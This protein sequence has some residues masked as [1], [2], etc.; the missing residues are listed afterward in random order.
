MI[1]S[2]LETLR[3]EFLR[4]AQGAPKLFRDLAKVEQYIGESYRTRALIELI[5][6]ADDAEATHFGL[7]A[8]RDGF[9]VGNDGR[10][11]TIQDVE[12][13]C[14][15]GSSNKYRGGNTIGYRGIGF[16]SVVNL[17]SAIYVVSDDFAFYFDKQKTQEALHS[18]EDVP[19]I[20]VPHPLA[21]ANAL[22]GDIHDF[23]SKFGYQTVFFFD[24]PNERI[25]LDELVGFDRS[26]LLFL[27][28]LRSLRID[29]HGV[30][31]DI[32][33]EFI[34][35]NHQNIV[36]LFE[37][38]ET[39]EWEVLSSNTNP[40]T[41]VAFRNLDGAI[42]PASLEQSVIHSFTPTVEFAGAYIKI[43]GDFTTDPSRKNVDMD[44]LS[45][46]SWE[47]AVGIIID[48]ILAVLAGDIA[49]PGVFTPFINVRPQETSRFKLL[50]LKALKD[51]F[52]QRE[53]TLAHGKRVTFA[54]IRLKPDWM[55]F[56]DYER[57]CDDGLSPIN[58]ELLVDYP[59]LILFLET[60][61]I[62][63]LT[64][65][66]IL[67]RLN[68]TDVTLTGSAEIFDKIVKQYRYD[69]DTKRVEQLKALKIFPVDKHLVS[70]KDVATTD[71]LR[72]EF[73]NHLQNQADLADVAMVLKKLDITIT[74][75]LLHPVQTP[76]RSIQQSSLPNDTPEA[77]Q[78]VFRIEPAIKKWRSAEQ[79]AAEYFKALR[80]VLSATDVSKANLGYDLEILLSDGNK[81]Y[82]EI[83]SVSAFTEPFRITTNE[84]SSAH[85]HG[86][87]YYIAVV[88]ND[89]PF[90]IKLIQNPVNTLPFEKKCEQWSWYCEQYETVLKDTARLF[91]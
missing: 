50:L 56:E 8:F 71:S 23:K 89:D 13:L 66:E 63:T 24:L 83:K 18:R 40:T 52:A 80:G 2:M 32:A 9:V 84:Y 90:Q 76:L 20:R 29:Y 88:I 19:L 26:S 91:Q 41:R 86:D 30:I 42:I 47:E 14:R 60:L 22:V 33:V 57:I 3:S 70:A 10:P 17:S 58:K 53:M 36:R 72:S 21:D 55:N 49:K 67:S 12:A 79:N 61:E 28:H 62:K 82:I 1:E 39:E 27:N 54:S 44:D 68:S 74:N 6:N 81:I 38:T 75:K 87:K 11:F 69:L 35:A 65:D 25:S 16:K 34:H 31:R 77:R 43:N 85:N 59:E 48:T 64:L 4:E 37:T 45:Q 46:K 78:N 15:S 5:Q 7:H 73:Q 51:G